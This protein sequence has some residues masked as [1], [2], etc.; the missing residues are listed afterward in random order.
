[1]IEDNNC[2]WWSIRHR[3]HGATCSAVLVWYNPGMRA[4]VSLAVNDRVV[5]FSQVSGSTYVLRH[6]LWM[7]YSQLPTTSSL[8]DVIFTAAYLCLYNMENHWV[9]YKS[10]MRAGSVSRHG[11]TVSRA[12]RQWQQ[13]GTGAA[14]AAAGAT[15]RAGMRRAMGGRPAPPASVSFGSG[16]FIV[17]IVG[18]CRR[19]R[20]VQFCKHL[21]RGISSFF[22]R[23][24]RRWKSRP[25]RAGPMHEILIAG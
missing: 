11:E 5:V 8:V 24:T 19:E 17:F 15:E 9:I 20:I 16:T 1:M 6:H 3:Q 23:G 10:A 4:Q 21:G 18:R 22:R 2:H 7:S 12:G 13:Q 14:A 25:S